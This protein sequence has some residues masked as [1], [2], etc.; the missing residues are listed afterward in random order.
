LAIRNKTLS[1]G[2]TTTSCITHYNKGYCFHIVEINH[3]SLNTFQ[4]MLF[5]TEIPK[6]CS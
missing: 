6:S 3:K 1:A 2:Y 4:P 5:K